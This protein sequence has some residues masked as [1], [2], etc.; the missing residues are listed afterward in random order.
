MEI[1]EHSLYWTEIYGGG[2][3]IYYY[4]LGKA[5][6][7]YKYIKVN[8]DPTSN[9]NSWGVPV[10]ETS[11]LPGERELKEGQIEDCAEILFYIDNFLSKKI[12]YK[13]E[14]LDSLKAIRHRIRSN[15]PLVPT[16]IEIKKIYYCSEEDSYYL[17][18]SI[19]EVD[20]FGWQVEVEIGQTLMLWSACCNIY[21]LQN[22]RLTPASEEM[23]ADIA[24][25]IGE[26]LETRIARARQ[27]VEEQEADVE[28][29]REIVD[30][31]S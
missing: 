25:F 7:F 15:H 27:I 6:D 24:K 30:G 5:D 18:T 16:N 1:K 19:G 26:E 31:A 22:M 21:D 12:A 10:I 4:I 20:I 13:E 14:S 3:G 29:I 11:V 8:L 17:F 23:A 28:I 2:Q 9:K